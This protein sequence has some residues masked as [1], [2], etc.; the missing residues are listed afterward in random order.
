MLEEINLPHEL[1]VIDITTGESGLP[2][3]LEL[4]PKGPGGKT[5][6]LFESGAT[7]QYLADKTGKPLSGDQQIRYETQQWV[8]FKWQQSGRLLVKPA[9]SKS[10]LGE[11]SRISVHCRKSRSGGQPAFVTGISASGQASI[12]AALPLS[13]VTSA[14]TAM[15]APLPTA[16]MRKTAS[17][18]LALS[19]PLMMTSTPSSANASAQAKPDPCSRHKQPP[20]FQSAPDPYPI[21][22][23]SLPRSMM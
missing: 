10:T 21:P 12:S 13:V 5:I 18:T 2:E 9:S 19:L 23:S 15:A 3:F 16:S 4:N 11:R 8:C 20:A 1:H 6:G 17:F 7:L 14:T 22:R